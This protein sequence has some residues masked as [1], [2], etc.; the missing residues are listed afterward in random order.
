MDP[1][2]LVGLL[3]Q[4]DRRRVVAALILGARSRDDVALATGL[5]GREIADAVTR[6]EQGG[7]LE[8]GE[9]GAL[10]LLEAAFEV[11]GRD[12][13]TAAPKHAP[14]ASPAD[15]VLSRSVVDGKIVCWPSKQ[16][17][18]LIVLDWL[19]Q[20]FEPGVRYSERQV[21][22]AILDA[23]EDTAAMRR[24]L[25]DRGMLDRSDGEYWRSGGSVPP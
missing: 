14:D 18:Q 24:Y 11:A 23:H 16:S 15:V 9:D 19:V 8:A 6:L 5:S 10:I 22:R 25:V 21:N 3:A 7:L 2:R 12:R 13:G 1:K 4:S 17:K 20:R